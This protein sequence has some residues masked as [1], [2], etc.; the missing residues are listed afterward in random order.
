MVEVLLE[1]AGIFYRKLLHPQLPEPEKIWKDI[2]SGKRK[3]KANGESFVSLCRLTWLAAMIRG[4][5]FAAALCLCFTILRH[6]SVVDPPISFTVEQHNMFVGASFF[7][8][9]QPPHPL[10]L[11]NPSPDA[12]ADSIVTSLFTQ[13]E[14]CK[15]AAII[16]ALAIVVSSISF[17]Y[18]MRTMED[19]IP[20]A[21]AN[22]KAGPRA[23]AAT[24]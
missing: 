1:I 5:A 9:P 24:A 11:V 17:N 19:L 7:K 14:I 21:T 6:V 22:S 10:N 13:L 3:T 4:V 15:F 23:R 16:S 20:E 12:I 2:R 18:L 8:R